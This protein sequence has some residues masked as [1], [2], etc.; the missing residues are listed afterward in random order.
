MSDLIRREDAI[1]AFIDAELHT[2]ADPDKMVQEILSKIPP[3]FKNKHEKLLPCTCGCNR[4]EH[5][6]KWVDDG[7][8]TGLK[9]KK[10]GKLVWGKNEEDARREWNKAIREG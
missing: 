7:T 2:Y 10:C 8:L 3:A 1:K 6:S 4:R 9:C 5:W